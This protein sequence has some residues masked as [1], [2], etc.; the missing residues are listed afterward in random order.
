MTKQIGSTESPDEPGEPTSFAETVKGLYKKHKMAIIGVGVA[1][2]VVTVAVIKYAN[3]QDITEDIESD[4]SDEPEELAELD[5][6]PT[7]GRCND[8]WLSDSIGKQG[9]CSGHGGVAA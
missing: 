4:E 3:G 6:T 1:A 7:P 5:E 2:F 8:G 9:A